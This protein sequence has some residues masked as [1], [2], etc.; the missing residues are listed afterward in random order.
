VALL[1]TRTSSPDRRPDD[2]G[3]AFL[4]AVY[5][6]HG[7]ALLAQARRLTGDPGRAEDVVQETLLR[8]WKNAAALSA[9][10]RPL[11]PWL[12]TVL[13]HVAV[14]EHRARRA[15]PTE[16]GGDLAEQLAAPEELDRAL[17]SWQ[18]QAAVRQL[19]AAHRAVL[20]E[21]YFRGRSVA[22]AAEVLGV[23]PGTVKSRSFYALRAL[24]LVLEEAG[25]GH[26]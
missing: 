17:E 5:A 10:D 4:T 7:A 16:V 25:W 11:R 21:L 23:P 22:E 2:D 1:R 12:F 3:A 20:L 19:S 15:R 13:S 26:E 8:A 14:S 24:R 6:E 18:V 9:D